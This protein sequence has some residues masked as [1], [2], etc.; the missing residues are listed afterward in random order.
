MK[1]QSFLITLFIIFYSL[2]ALAQEHMIH[3]DSGWVKINTNLTEFYI[4]INNDYASIKK[5]TPNDVIKLPAKKN[6]LTLVWKNIN[7]WKT[8]LT[9]IPND[10]S[11]IGINFGSLSK[12]ATNS[13]YFNIKNNKNIE[14]RL[15]P[16][17]ELK[18]GGRS[19]TKT[20]YDSLVAPGTYQIDIMTSSS[21]WE[22]KKISIY[23]GKITRFTYQ[24]TEISP[25]SP[26][27]YF[28]PSAG[29]WHH[30]KKSKGILSLAALT[31]VTIPFISNSQEFIDARNSFNDYETRFYNASDNIKN[32]IYYKYLADSER[33]IMIDTRRKLFIY[34]AG[35]AV[36]YGLTVWDSM[37][38][39]TTSYLKPSIE[40][41]LA[42]SGSGTVFYPK[43][44][45][46]HEF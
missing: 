5:L 30:K 34:G 7:D 33:D 44:V 22:S 18:F 31:L 12:V 17:Y 23:P 19:I 40:T 20:S 28:I 37:K 16:G 38:I 2:G 43:L 41:I 15:I 13:S 21:N 42:N 25:K 10:T 1:H 9:V 4:I 46:T 8:S 26:S 32:A 24:V 11:S 29:Y 6:E 36:I 3:S 35:F 27:F 39:G 45:Y 14:L